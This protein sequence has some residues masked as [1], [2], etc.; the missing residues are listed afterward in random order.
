MNRHSNTN[1]TTTTDDDV[2]PSRGAS[3]EP[4]DA[5][6]VNLTAAQIRKNEAVEK[7]EAAELAEM[8]QL[9]TEIEE[10]EKEI[11]IEDEDE[12]ETEEER[13]DN[14][15]PAADDSRPFQ[16]ALRERR[17]LLPTRPENAGAAWVATNAQAI[18]RVRDFY[19][20]PASVP[21]ARIPRFFRH[22]P[23]VV[24]SVHMEV[25]KRK[26][27]LRRKKTSEYELLK[28]TTQALRVAIDQVCA[29]IVWE[30]EAAAGEDF[31]QELDRA[32][33][34]S[35]LEHPREALGEGVFHLSEEDETAFLEAILASESE[36]AGHGTARLIAEVQRPRLAEEAGSRYRVRARSSLRTELFVDRSE[37]T[38]VSEDASDDEMEWF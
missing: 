7:A 3:F 18:R 27:P 31:P 8:D 9:L 32:A 28:S 17:H 21:T 23:D 6:A 16:W 5:D 24:A 25:V 26:A 2:C 19:S 15:A 33:F 20:I 37:A 38:K 4:V 34:E 14:P 29:R 13:Q 36:S 12:D 1:T 30:D 22:H 11:P 10:L 35:G